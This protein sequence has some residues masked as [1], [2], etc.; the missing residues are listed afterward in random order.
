M[1][2]SMN[3]IFEEIIKYLK[4]LAPQVL[5][6][7]IRMWCGNSSKLRLL[8]LMD[9]HLAHHRGQLVVYLRLNGIKPPSYAG[10]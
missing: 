2:A 10:W 3:L 7:D 5:Q 6:E 1:I 9:N 4:K 8:N